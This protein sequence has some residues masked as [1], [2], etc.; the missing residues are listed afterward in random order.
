MKDVLNTRGTTEKVLGT[1]EKFCKLGLAVALI[2]GAALTAQAAPTIYDP[3]NGEEHLYQ[4]FSDFGGAN[5]LS[6]QAIANKVPIVETLPAGQITIT[7]YAVWAAFTQNPGVYSAGNPNST[8]QYLAP[9]TG[10][11][12]TNGDVTQT[13]SAKPI[14]VN[15]PFGFFDDTSGGGIKYTQLGL[16]DSGQLGQSNGLIFEISPT[17][18]IVAF[19]DGEGPNA[20]GD[21][22]YNDLVLNVKY[23][24]VPVPAAILLFAPGLAGLAAVRRKFKK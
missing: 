2:L 23:S 4:I 12:P 19:E 5:F 6:S 8:M 11:F 24:P 22:D 10:V 21:Q 3:S 18:Y 15:T 7:G 1:V 13:I 16:N 14:T 9:F 17:H 20:L